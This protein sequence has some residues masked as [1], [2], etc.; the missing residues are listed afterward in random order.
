MKNVNRMLIS[1]LQFFHHKRSSS[2]KVWRL[3][4]RWFFERQKK[5]LISTLS[6]DQE[7]HSEF[8]ITINNEKKIDWVSFVLSNTMDLMDWTFA[9]KCIIYRKWNQWLK[10]WCR[11]FF[12]FCRWL[13]WFEMCVCCCQ[14]PLLHRKLISIWWGS[15]IQA[16]I[17]SQ[18]LVDSIRSN[19]IFLI[20]L[21]VIKNN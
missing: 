7:C 3:Y 8:E 13:L 1:I 15:S 9:S 2:L 5:K 21:R 10:N 20:E 11:F 14:R 17:M 4:F 16:E 19:N 6:I 12:F 18:Y